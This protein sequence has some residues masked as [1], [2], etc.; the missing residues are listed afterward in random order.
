MMCSLQTQSILP[1]APLSLL[2]T[3]REPYATE[4]VCP[5]RVNMQEEAETSEWPKL[6]RGGE[7]Y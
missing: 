4:C 6:I 5:V 7:N 2:E 3:P 1:L